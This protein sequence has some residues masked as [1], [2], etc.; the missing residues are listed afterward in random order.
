MYARDLRAWSHL[1]AWVGLIGSLILGLLLFSIGSC[2]SKTTYYQNSFIREYKKSEDKIMKKKMK[3][4]ADKLA[5]AYGKRRRQA[6]AYL[7]LSSNSWILQNTRYYLN[8]SFLAVTMR[9]QGMKL[10]M[11]TAGQ[12]IFS[13]LARLTLPWL[14]K[15]LILRSTGTM[16]N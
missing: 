4:R 10:L 15:T 8:L 14:K 3:E 16:K 13:A 9:F 6:Q 11:L 5:A 2:N 12:T 7:F 1:V